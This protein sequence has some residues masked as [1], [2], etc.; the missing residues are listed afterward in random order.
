RQAVRPRRA[1]GG[2]GRPAGAAL[3]ALDR[4]VD[5]VRLEI[6]EAPIVARMVGAIGMLAVL[7]ATAF[8]IALL[9][10]SNLRSSTDEQ[11]QA[12][13][14]TTASL[15]LERVVDE[16]EQSLRGFVLTRNSRIRDSW[17]RARADL[18]P[19]IGELE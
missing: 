13:R 7:V 3:M 1:L 15:R 12:N 10:M 6:D 16:L 17:D 19:A 4:I 14:V 8:A 2:R 11:V 5:R 9:A 18:T